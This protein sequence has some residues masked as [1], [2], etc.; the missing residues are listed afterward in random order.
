MIPKKKE[1]RIMKIH[2]LMGERLSPIID[3][4]QLQDKLNA[5][6]IYGACGSSAMSCPPTQLVT[7]HEM[8]FF[9]FMR[10]YLRRNK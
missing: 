4:L 8:K 7:D 2:E 1:Y 3:N 6:S 5:R 9:G 10:D